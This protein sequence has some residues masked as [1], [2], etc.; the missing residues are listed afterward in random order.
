[1]VDTRGR[2]GES[3]LAHLP[4][5][6]EGSVPATI[7]QVGYR[8]TESVNEFTSAQQCLQDS[9]DQVRDEYTA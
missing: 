7:L 9:G 1:M 2:Y 6:S 4:H 5:K 8:V 3:T